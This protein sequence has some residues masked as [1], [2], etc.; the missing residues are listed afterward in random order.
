M[1]KKIVKLKHSIP[2]PQ[3]KGEDISTNELK[4]GR[5]KVKHLKLLPSDFAE[6]GGSLSPSEIIP[7]IAGLANISEESAG[8]IDL[9][10]IDEVAEALQ[11]FLEESLGDGKK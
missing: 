4:F 5:L 10:D 11:I 3:E 1:D 2:I 9:A 6:K 7:L 8:E